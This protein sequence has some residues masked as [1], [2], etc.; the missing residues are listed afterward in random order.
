MN[1]KEIVAAQGVKICGKD[2]EKALAGTQVF[3]AE[4]PDEVEILKVGRS[5]P[6]EGRRSLFRNRFARRSK[7]PRS[8]IPLNRSSFQIRACTCRRRRWDR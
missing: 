3:V 4:H 1:H 2:L 7:R 5:I 8:P 6:R